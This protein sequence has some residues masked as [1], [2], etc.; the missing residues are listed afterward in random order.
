[1]IC[2]NISV[3]AEIK[4]ILYINESNGSKGTLIK[5]FIINYLSPKTILDKSGINSLG[6]LQI[7]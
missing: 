4:L 3:D 5:V 2:M 1:M 7:K 6:I